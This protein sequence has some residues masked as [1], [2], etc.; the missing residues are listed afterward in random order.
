MQWARERTSYFR[1][2][3]SPMEGTSDGNDGNS[4]MSRGARSARVR[5]WGAHRQEL[6]RARQLW[7]PHRRRQRTN[8]QPLPPACEM[9]SGHPVRRCCDR[10]DGRGGPPRERIG[11]ESACPPAVHAGGVGGQSAGVGRGATWTGETRDCNAPQVFMGGTRDRNALEIAVTLP[12]GGRF[13]ASASG[14]RSQLFRR[15]SA[16]GSGSGHG[17][18]TRP[19]TGASVDLSH[20]DNDGRTPA[21]RAAA[22]GHVEALRMLQGA[23]VDLSHAANDGGTPAHSAAGGGHVEALRMLQG[24]SVDLSHGNNRGRTPAHEAAGRGHVE[25][26]RVL[27][28]A[29]ADL[30]HGDNDGS[31]P[32]HSAAGGGHVEALRVLQD[33][34][35]DLSHGANDGG[36]PAHEAAARGHVE[37]LRMLQGAGADLSHGDNGRGGVAAIRT[38]ERG[39]PLRSGLGSKAAAG[40]HVEAL[41]MLQDAIALTLQWAWFA[42]AE[43]G[44]VEMM[45]ELLEKGAK[46]DAQNRKG[47]T[48]LTVALAEGKE[49]AA[50]ALLEAGAGVNAGTG[51]RPLHAA[52]EKG[53]VEM[54]RE[55]V[56]KGA[57]VDAED[58]HGRT[59]LTVALEFEQKGAARALLEARLE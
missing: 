30:S 56:G 47:C 18:T 13:A 54:V 37:A 44:L 24:A 5:S 20:A 21:H 49:A 28:G 23:S 33:A 34:G 35:V 57:E 7:H 3:L 10:W 19:P 36:T 31:T 51:Q 38:P 40:G 12:G 6:I 39:T 29:G 16:L 52:A 15:M 41:R 32:A 53:M 42:A 9:R 22:G 4:A 25:A 8:S 45:R 50:R 14:Q 55:L 26:L 58:G 43:F 17:Y 48:A 11:A 46:V 27:Q 59:A 2:P 1:L